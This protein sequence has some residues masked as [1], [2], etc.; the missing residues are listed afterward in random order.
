MTRSGR[1]E[2][3]IAA[4]PMR[5]SLKV[6]EDRLLAGERWVES[7]LVFT[8][9][10]GTPMDGPAVT[11]RLHRLLAAAGLAQMRFH[12]LRHSYATLLHAQGVDARVAMELLGHSDVRL[13]Q[14]L[15]THVLPEL[16]K[17]A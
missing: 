6:L 4:E 10:R 12:D 3:T 14:N 9:T 13:T 15:Y 2:L 1:S 5:V 16:K 11:R 8:T 17:D 7:E